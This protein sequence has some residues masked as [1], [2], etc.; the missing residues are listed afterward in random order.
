MTVLEKVRAKIG[1]ARKALASAGDSVEGVR[2]AIRQLE[3]ERQAVQSAPVPLA[4][5]VEA[6]EQT[7]DRLC[8]AAQYDTADS[9]LFAAQRGQPVGIDVHSHMGANFGFLVQCL[10]APLRAALVVKLEEDYRDL[11][12]GL[13]ADARAEKLAQLDRE[14]LEL[15]HQEEALITELA[16]LGIEVSRRGD[17]DPRAV[18]G[19]SE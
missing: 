3:A 11:Q 16:G 4:E 10:R 5:A 19:L 1:A 9:V 15:G 13:P 7:I 8:G 14:L 17:A 12:P 2:E 6:V 18:L